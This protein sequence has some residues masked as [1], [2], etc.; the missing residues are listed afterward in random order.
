MR[1]V[2]QR[3]SSGRVV[4]DGQE[5][6]ALDGPGLVVLVGV[7]VEDGPDDAAQVARKVADLRVLRGE[8]S[9]V[10]AGAP[11]IVVSQFTLLAD[12]RKGRRPTWA[13]A[14]RG[15]VAEPLVAAVVGALRERGLRVGTGVFGAD[16][17]VELVNDGPVTI[18][19]DTRSPA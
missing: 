19:L 12:T 4:V 16:M 14:A 13:G 15:D 11:V 1:A 9:A 5:V 6:A 17:A 7:S 10:D 8:L 18:L 2:V 3:A